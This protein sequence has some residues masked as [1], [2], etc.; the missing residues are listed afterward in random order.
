[1]DVI[2]KTKNMKIAFLLIAISGMIVS[3]CTNKEPKDYLAAMKSN[4]MNLLR[5]YIAT[6]PDVSEEH[7]TNVTQR[8]EELEL[9]SATFA[10]IKAEKDVLARY[11]LCENYVASPEG[12]HI[13]EVKAIMKK[14]QS[15]YTRIMEERERERILAEQQAEYERRYGDFIR[16]VKNRWFISGDP[17][18]R[19]SFRIVV[20][21]PDNKGVGRA[22]LMDGDADFYGCYTYEI[23]DDY[24]IHA[25]SIKGGGIEIWKI[26]NDYLYRMDAGIIYQRYMMDEGAYEIVDEAMKRVEIDQ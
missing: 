22:V 10:S 20:G 7:F 12:L 3:S 18:R 25:R 13:A 1:M 19:L 24:E 21:L 11:Q 17:S 6:Y 2:I 15:E 8:L 4:N 26:Y 5:T 9:D 23:F 16:R 14:D